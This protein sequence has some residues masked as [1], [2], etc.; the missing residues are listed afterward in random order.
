DSDSLSP[1]VSAPGLGLV[2]A[3]VSPQE[4]RPPKE[5]EP[6]SVTPTNPAWTHRHK[7]SGQPARHDLFDHIWLSPALANRQNG[8]W[9]DR[10]TRHSGDGSDHD[11]AWV[12]L[13]L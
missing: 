11:P 2:N 7:E 3:L 12:R 8:A 4:T 10:R 6:P 13:D 9:I 1:L 5:E